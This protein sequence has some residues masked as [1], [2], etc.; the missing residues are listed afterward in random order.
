MRFRLPLGRTL[1]F[2]C[3][4]LFAMVALLPLRLAIGWLDFDEQ[5][6]SA[7]D[8]QGSIWFGAL[9]EA[10]F[11]S[12]PVGDVT[13]GLRSAPL[14]LGRARVDMERK[15]ETDPLKL[16]LTASR[17][18]FGIDDVKGAFAAGDLFAPLPISRVTADDLTAHF[19]DGTCT[20]AEG[21]VT[22]EIATDVAGVSLPG[23]FSGNARCEGGLLLLP[24][25]SQSGLET[26]NLRIGGD[27]RYRVELV[28]RPPNPALA[29]RLVAAGFVLGSD[30]AYT[31]RTEGVIG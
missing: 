25:T 19:A 12:V 8:V 16:S 9:S 15:A 5:G 28:V 14:L 24:L 17:H 11:G 2:A 29:E 7:R 26:F 22:A 23:G 4:F 21:R 13:A 20:S 10:R 18:S 3:V 27:A 30:G 1:L 6:L 31:L